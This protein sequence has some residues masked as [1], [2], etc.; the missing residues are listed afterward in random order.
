MRSKRKLTRSNSSEE[1]C[2]YGLLKTAITA[3]TL[4]SAAGI[5]MAVCRSCKFAKNKTV[6][7]YDP[8]DELRASVA[9]S[10]TSIEQVL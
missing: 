10:V 5:L 6:L 7:S 8:D 1:L 9:S 2:N 3:K 4:T